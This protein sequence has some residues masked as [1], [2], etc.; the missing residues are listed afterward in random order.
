V[1]TEG[2]VNRESQVLLFNSIG[3][4]VHQQTYGEDQRLTLHLN[5]FQNGVYILQVRTENGVVSKKVVLEQ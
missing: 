4:R 2:K 5:D 1:A 3:Q